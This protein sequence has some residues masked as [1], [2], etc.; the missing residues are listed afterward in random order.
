MARLKTVFEVKTFWHEDVIAAWLATANHA[1]VDKPEKLREFLLA[2]QT[3]YD[4]RWKADSK[5][6]NGAV[7]WLKNLLKGDL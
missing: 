1:D 6:G 5:G 4:N 3:E 7:E 2:I